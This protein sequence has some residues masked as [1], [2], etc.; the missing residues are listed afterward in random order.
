GP[1][2]PTNGEAE[3]RRGLSAMAMGLVGSEILKI[4]AEVR[5][6]QAE[7]HK[8]VNLTVGDFS[9]TEF[10]IPAKLE[11]GIAA[12]LAEGQTNYPPSDGLLELRKAVVAFLD[13]VQGI[14][15]PLDSVLICGGARPLLYGA[16]RAVLDPGETVLYPVPS[17]NNNHYC[18]LAG[19]D[20]IVVR[21]RPENA[22]LPAPE[23]LVP[24]LPRARLL[25]LNSP[26]NPTGTAF[27]AAA[28]QKIAEA[29]ADENRK[30]ASTGAR[31]LM[32]VYDQVYSCLTEQPGQHVDPVRLVPELAPYV[33]LIDGISKAFAATGLRVG[34]SCAAPAVTARMRD[35]LG[36]VGAWAPRPEQRATALLLEDAAA[37]DGYLTEIRAGV[38]TRLH[39]LYDGIA[40]LGA[41][42]FPVA[43]IP[44]A[45]AIY[46]SAK[47]ALH[48][49]IPGCTTNEDV[50]R[51]LLREAGMAVVPFQAFAYPEDDGWFR[52]SVGAVSVAQC[53]DAVARLGDALRRA[54]G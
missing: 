14:R 22:F 12:A 27:S 2:L 20:E 48:G 46:L 38:S 41:E 52:L 6:M 7:G 49:K 40:A 51:W 35:L 37:V 28:L 4:A 10:R 11:S 44:P 34:W 42:G 30:R 23:D 21:S 50:R 13:R 16:Y 1:Y 26:L 43:A 29:V 45:G 15:Y 8:I 54:K 18:H 36:H 39:A 19:A 31:S 24:H 32:V 33:I 53:H 3:A 17:W 25:V 47:F 9:P 5:V